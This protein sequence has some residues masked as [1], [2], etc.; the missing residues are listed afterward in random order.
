LHNQC[1]QAVSGSR[2]KCL[3]LTFE[4]K[5]K[6]IWKKLGLSLAALLLVCCVLGVVWLWVMWEIGELGNWGLESG[7]YGQFNRVKHVLGE[8]P[9][10]NITNDWQHHDITLED[11]GFYLMVDGSRSVRVDFL[12]NSPQMKLRDK[13]LIRKFVEEKIDDGSNAVSHGAALPRRP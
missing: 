7:Y 3:T 8:M 4:Q 12:E 10:V 5:M 6:M 2:L 1:V 13:T 9:R 11:F